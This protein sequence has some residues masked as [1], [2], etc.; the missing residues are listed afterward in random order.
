[1]QMAGER[2]WTA[3]RVRYG[4][5]VDMS[6]Q[7]FT[8]FRIQVAGSLRRDPGRMARFQREAEVLASLNHPNI[9][10][11]YGVEERALVM[12][13]VKARRWRVPAKFRSEDR[14]SP[15]R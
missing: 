15:S 12:E 7:H 14:P 6:D 3:N 13:L 11:I 4:E 10:A 9:A 5:F 8:D 2:M 1:M